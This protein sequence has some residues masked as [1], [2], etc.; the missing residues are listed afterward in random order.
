MAV[1]TPDSTPLPHA[2]PLPARQVGD[3]MLVR[4]PDTGE[5]HFLN[6]TAALIWGLCDGTT[7]VAQCEAQ[8]RA[9]FRIPE[10]IDLRADIDEVVCGFR[11]RGMLGE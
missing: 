8:L 1:R 5:V 2:K 6:P 9:R 3:E 7:S 4:S 11:E 10:S